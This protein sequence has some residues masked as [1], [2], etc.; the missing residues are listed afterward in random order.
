[1]VMN[2]DTVIETQKFA[3]QVRQR[4][5]VTIPQKVRAALSIDE[6]DVLTAVQVGEALVLTPK[7]L[8]G[9]DLADKF[10]RLMEQQGVSLADLLEDMP[11]IREELYQER[12]GRS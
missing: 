9:P 2:A 3:I 5:Q 4:G 6:G 1:M 11:Q 8:K 10:A 12:Y 7:R